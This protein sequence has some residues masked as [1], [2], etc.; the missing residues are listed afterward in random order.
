MKRILVVGAGFTGAT[1]ARTL[2]ENGYEVEVVDSR[3]H[4]A[5]NAYDEEIHGIR[6]HKYGPHLF[7][8]KNKEVWDFLNRFSLWT[9]YVHK[10]SALYNGEYL[11]FPPNDITIKSVAKE[12][13]VDVFYRPYTELMW[14]RPLEKVAPSI[15]D[16]VPIR[17]GVKNSYFPDATYQGLPECGYTMLVSNM[18]DHPNIRL[19]VN[20]KAHREDVQS[21]GYLYVF[22]S[23]SI[24]EYFSFCAGTLPYRSVK[25]DTELVRNSGFVQPTATVN[26]TEGKY[27]TRSTEWKHLPNSNCPNNYSLITTEYPCDYL[28]NNMERFYPVRDLESLSS[29]SRYEELTKQEKNISFVGRCGSFVYIDMD[30]A[31]NMG[32]QHSKRFLSK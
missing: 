10:V 26:Y 7:H 15:L 6:V 5:G 18:L 29:Y 31:V 22:Y 30:Q 13:L 23:G 20:C 2:A 27:R 1:I 24:D 16:R 17:E 14:N 19:Y 3:S 32:L 21:G 8:T 25:F 9:P 4:L 11:P 12:K 28:Q